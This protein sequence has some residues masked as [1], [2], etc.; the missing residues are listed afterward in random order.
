MNNGERKSMINLILIM[1]DMLRD[2]YNVKTVRDMGGVWE[3]QFIC[4]IV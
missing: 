2:V 1:G 3:F 4:S